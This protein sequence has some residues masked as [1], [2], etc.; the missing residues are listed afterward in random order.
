ERSGA[1]LA[2]YGGGAVL[3]YYANPR[4]ALEAETGL[5]DTALA[6]RIISERGRPG[7][8]KPATADDLTARGIHLIFQQEQRFGLPDVKRRK[9]ILGGVPFLIHTYENTVMEILREMPDVEFVYF[10]TFLDSY[11]INLERIPTEELA[12]EYERFS[13]YYFQHNNDPER[14]AHFIRELRRRHRP[15]TKPGGPAVQ[16]VT[17]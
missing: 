1:S 8:E 9:L 17:P 10:P 3:A 2:F 12:Q 7:H 6:H 13:S 14:E 16:P 11:I 4:V 15:P 5:T